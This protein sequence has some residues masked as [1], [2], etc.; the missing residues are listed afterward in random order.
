MVKKNVFFKLV[1]VLTCYQL[2]RHLVDQIQILFA[3]A[4]WT[5]KEAWV[6]P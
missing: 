2:I 3:V 5:L 6:A 1:V 4:A